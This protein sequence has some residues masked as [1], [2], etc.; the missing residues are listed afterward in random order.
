MDVLKK[1]GFGIEGTL[2]VLGICFLLGGCL[3]LIGLYIEVF[4][5]LLSVLFHE[6]LLDRFDSY[7]RISG[8]TCVFCMFALLLHESIAIGLGEMDGLDLFL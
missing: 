4:P 2:F 6:F 8:W 1:G 3:R 7:L 5:L